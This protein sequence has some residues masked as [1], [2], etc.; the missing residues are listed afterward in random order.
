MVGLTSQGAYLDRATSTRGYPMLTA[1]FNS[2]LSACQDVLLAGAGGGY[3]VAGAIPLALALRAAGKR[4]HLASLSFSSLRAKLGLQP[5]EGA[6]R[7]FRMKPAHASRQVYCPEAWISRWLA[8]EQGWDCPV[9][10]FEQTGVKPLLGSYE[11]LR[12]ELN[13]DAVVLVD[14]GIDLILRGDETSI[15]T[16]AEDLTSLAAVAQLDVPVKLVACVGLGAEIRNGIPHAQAFE[17]IAALTEAGAYLGACSLS[18][19]GEHE[20]QYLSAMEYVFEGQSELR[21]SHVHAVVLR[22]L[23]GEFGAQPGEADVWISPLLSMYWYFN[24]DTVAAQN[25]FVGELGWTESLMQVVRYLEGLRRDV[26]VKPTSRIP[27]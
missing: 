4:V 9:W 8:E 16:P 18:G 22:S 23:A 17:R 7:L 3:D 21:R 12:R 6:D 26:D 13:L 15:G 24:L 1:A 5:V 19:S 10:C 25:L 14:G 11:H 27:I 2:R 20:R